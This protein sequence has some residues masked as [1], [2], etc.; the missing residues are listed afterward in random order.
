M[1]FSSLL[2]LLEREVAVSLYPSFKLFN[3]LKDFHENP[4]EHC[5]T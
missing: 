5:A 2:P 3:Q 1:S 4:Y